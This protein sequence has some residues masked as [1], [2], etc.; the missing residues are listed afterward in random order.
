[1]KR[2]LSAIIL[3]PLTLLAVIYAPPI[4][5][6]IGIGLLG[7]VCLYEYFGLI[8]AL[9][10]RIRPWFGY[11]VFWIL[12]IILYQGR[13]P[14]L[15]ILALVLIAAFISASWRRSLTVRD[16]TTGV[17]AEFFGILYITLCLFPALPIRFD[18][19]L[20]LHWTLLALLVI[21]GGD[22][23]ALVVGKKIGKRPFAPVLS[24]NK[25]NEGALAGL[26]AGIGIAVALQQFLF[27]ELPL[28]HVIA[29]SILLG[30]F[31]QLGD[32]AESMIKRAAGIKDSSRLIPGH[33][34]VLDRMDSLLF[35][36][37]VLYGYLLLI[38]G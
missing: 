32:L 7:T 14:F 15:P 10:I 18:F 24:P 34:G 27:T 1:M 36:F 37:P 17:M 26:L 6:L 25:T 31:G 8:R 21:W 19:S 9:D 11:G 35:A 29:V 28:G 30:I 16:R 4:C 23:F 2:I 22:T 5:Y 3:I 20:G 33:G 38:Y 12:L 13:L